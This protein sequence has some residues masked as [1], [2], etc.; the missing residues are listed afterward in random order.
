M[1][2][3]HEGLSNER[4]QR[5]ARRRAD[6]WDRVKFLLL[7]V[8]VVV[9]SV[10]SQVNPPFVPLAAALAEFFGSAGG[11]TV[12][13]FAA[14][15]LLRQIHYLISER[16][17]RY[18]T[19]FTD[20]VFGGFERLLTRRFK[21]WT[22][23]R[24]G[25]MIR[26]LVF[27]SVYAVVADALL[28]QVS[29]PLEAVTQAPALA[30]EVIPFILQFAVYLF[31]IVGQFGFL[32]WFL[33]RGGVDT[34]MP[35]EIKTRFSDVWGQDHVLALLRENIAFLERPDEIEAKGGYIPGGILLWGPPGTGKTLMAEAVAGETGRPFVFVDPGAFINMFMGVGI[36]K[37]KSLY[38]KLRKLSLRHGGVIVFFDEADSLGSRGSLTGL[39]MPGM[40]QPNA[41]LAARFGCNG[42]SYLS[43]QALGA[44]LDDMGV[45]P[46]T[47]EAPRRS[48]KDRVIMAGMGGGGGMGTLQALLTEMNGLTK[49]RGLFNRLR[50]MLGFRPKPPPKYRI[51]H[52]MATNMPNALDEAML[53]PGRIDRIFK[54]GYPSKEGRRATLEGYLAKVSNELTP[55]EV[56]KL[57]VVTPYY[58]GAKIKDLVNEALIQ[59]IRDGRNA[60][61][62][63]D[64]WRAKALKELGPPEDA[65]YIQR[66]R[67]AVAI[68]EASH[69]VVAH[70]MRRHM[71][72]DLVTIERHG[73]TGGMVKN[74]LSEDRFTQWKSEFET[75]IMV[76]L[77]SLA[78]ER[79][80]FGD[81]NSSGVTGDL[82]S[83]TTVA[84]F[85]EGVWGMGDGLVSHTVH[86]TEMGQSGNPASAALRS[87]RDEIEERLEALYQ[88]AWALLDEHREQVLAL[89]AVLEERKTIS[90]DEVSEIMGSPPGARSMREP[91]GWSAVDER[92]AEERRLSALARL[93]A[94]SHSH[95][96]SADGGAEADQDL[97]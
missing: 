36:I 86:Q 13:V 39:G 54:V 27:V 52:I 29:S 20:G 16:S 70:L 69:A 41:A 28:D 97:D 12:A 91:K 49:P 31:I 90:G 92:T 21:P 53:R 78:G 17:P 74:L 2:R 30:M 45:E 34:V 38:R 66:E 85:M 32:F 26:W 59:A 40:A 87:R 8:V 35:E 67:H 5:S 14:L 89:A 61:E 43:P 88:R 75:D 55:G 77:A 37:V 65:E 11:R 68:H 24:V 23:F 42:Y 79:M 84:A 80:F 58:S 83:A 72:I 25:R 95:T 6:S 4:V 62:W 71:A 57:A 10:G 48:L 19:F 81:D 63:Q 1:A 15:E 94:G 46:Q 7:A 73:D 47:D 50:K 76:S 60:I 82:R 96:T 64:I 22:R 18:H 3:E 9:V 33:S 51:L 93:P 56:E 44:L